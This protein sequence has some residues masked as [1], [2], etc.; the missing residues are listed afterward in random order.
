MENGGGALLDKGKVASP[1][2]RD[3]EA[4]EER[5]RLSLST[6]PVVAPLGIPFWEASLGGASEET[7]LIS[8][9]AMAV[10]DCKTQRC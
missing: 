4:E 7:W 3:E 10:V 9:V 2:S 8:L 1:V 5:G 6:T